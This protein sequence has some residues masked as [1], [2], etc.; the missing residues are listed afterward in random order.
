VPA[1]RVSNEIVHQIDLFTTLANLVGGKVPTDRQIDGMDQSNF[2]VGRTDKSAREGFV[3][4][5]G[6]NIFGVKWRNWKMLTKDF[7]NAKGTGKIVQHGVPF[8]YNLYNDPK[9]EYP[10]TMKTPEYFWVRW[11]CAK[12]MGEHLTSLAQEPPIKPGTP[13][14]YMPGNK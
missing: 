4:Y 11:P 14:P 1:G 12:I 13:D 10:L 7:D 5:V 2:F 9:E 8:F 3:V 6:E